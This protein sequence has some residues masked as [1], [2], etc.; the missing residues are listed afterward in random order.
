MQV[1]DR[2]R[3]PRAVRALVESH[4]PAAHPLPR[5]GDHPGGGADVGF[6]D[7]GDLCD[8]VRR[9]VRQERRH[10]V[11]AVGVHG[12]EF[13]IDVAALDEQVQQPV[14]QCQVGTG[15]D[16]QEQVGAFGGGSATRVDDDQ[17]RARLEPVGHPQIQDGMAVRHVR[18]HDEK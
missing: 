8:A 17:L 2:V 18:A 9:V 12:D 6:G 11:P 15:L 10:G 16:L 7:A 3:V 5:L 14:E 1:A 4:R 13:R